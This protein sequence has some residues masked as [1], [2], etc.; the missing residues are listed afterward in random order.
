MTSLVGMPGPRILAI[1]AVT[2][3]LVGLLPGA[4]P[5]RAVARAAEPTG[6]I[7]PGA[8]GRTSLDLEATYDVRLRLSYRSRSISVVSLMEVRN[9][10]GGPIDRI[11]L[12][13]V[14]ARLGRLRITGLTVDG[15]A[16]SPTIRDQTIVVPLG[17]I[18]PDDA[19]T[20]VRI[21][22]TATAR[23]TT[24]GSD[25]LFAR[26]NGV[27]QLYRWLPWV[28]RVHPFARP[29]HGDPFVTPTSPSVRVRITTDR[30]MRLATSGRR[31]ATSGLSSTWLAHDVRDFVI[32]ASPL[33]TARTARLGS[34]VVRVYA[35]PSGNGSR[36][37]ALAL[38]AL[39]RY[40][41]LMGPYPYPTFVVAESGGGYGMEAPGLIWIPR[42]LAT[43]RLPWLVSHEV[44]HQWFYALVGNDQAL[45]P[46][47]DEAMADF[48][49]RFI[50]GTGRSSRCATDTLD[51]SIYRYSASCYFEVV[52][53]QGGRVLD[54]LR[55][56][57]G[58]TA[59]WVG[60]RDYLTA[61]RFG[62]GGTRLLLETLDAHTP[63][64]LRGP[65]RPRFPTIL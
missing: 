18:L 54:G 27:I 24:A 16:I 13:T 33:W 51:R 36:L 50:T 22:F 57:M 44:A 48:L 4:D 26:A 63:L 1:A 52:Y 38:R 60:I 10:S 55:R 25:W 59:F 34:I 32:A 28:S 65:L 62:I 56:R 53:V 15:R 35:F 2:A 37:M 41:A 14:A 46:F 21:A 43:G 58:S 40:Q 31:I 23:R 17:G 6:T 39:R 8:V 61:N 64:D 7:V 42:G 45:E 5:G 30:A 19:T 11:E 9:R 29:G 47:A 20:T 12:N 3:L 49:A